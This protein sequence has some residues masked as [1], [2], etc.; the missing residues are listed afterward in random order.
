M[1]TRILLVDDHALVRRGFAAL[2]GLDGRFA[3]VA[4]A[5]NGEQALLELERCQPDLVLLDLSM[6]KMDGLAPL[7]HLKGRRGAPRV[8]VVSMYD[9]PQFVARALA[10]GADGY[11]LKQALDVE[12]VRAAAARGLVLMPRR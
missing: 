6:P 3:V 8:L 10:A 9:D 4:E 1:P 2:L 7:R 11:V 12:L 5:G